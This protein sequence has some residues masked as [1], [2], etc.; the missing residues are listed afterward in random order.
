[1]TPTD[2]EAACKY[3]GTTWGERHFNPCRYAGEWFGKS[4][5]DTLRSQLADA[6]EALTIAHGVGSAGR[7]EEIRCLT[8]E[9]N[10]LSARV[11]ELES[12]K[13]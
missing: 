8:E 2:T 6:N 3:C 7:N 4:E 12:D 9:R 1:M 13:K 5:I 10:N 11:K